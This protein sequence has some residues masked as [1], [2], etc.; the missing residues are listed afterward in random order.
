MNLSD[1]LNKS[2]ECENDFSSEGI[3]ITGSIT[4]DGQGYTI[5]AKGK[6]RIFHVNSLQKT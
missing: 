6:A 2:Y 5:D 4:I 1:E 3:V